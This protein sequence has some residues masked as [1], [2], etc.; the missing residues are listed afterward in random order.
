M[1]SIEIAEKYGF[2]PY[3]RKLRRGFRAHFSIRLDGV[4]LHIDSSPGEGWNLITH[5][6]S[7]HHGS[8]NM[9]NSSA[10]AS[11]ETA[12]ILEI[13]TRRKFSGMTFEVGS[14]LNLSGI[15]IKTYPTYHIKGAAAFLIKKARVLITGDVKNWRSLPKCDVLVT[16]A[17]YG[18]PSY[19][20]EDEIDKLLSAAER[21]SVFGAYPIGKAQRVAEILLNE[22][23]EFTAERRIRSICEALG[24][25][26]G[27]S[28]SLIVPPRK[29]SRY[30]GYILTA[31][32]FYRWPRIVLSDHID[33]SGIL[34]MVEHCNAE[35]VIFYHGCPTKRLKEDLSGMGVSSST[36]RDIDVYL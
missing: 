11:S 22:G 14:S 9:K 13:T 24:L 20:F 31:Q 12:K 19:T 26:V 30:R 35:H 6:H 3:R 32:R 34:R 36:L 8:K 33:Y 4:D 18:H 5:A 17:T 15:K 16:E 29:L 27:D 23:Y 28:G 7:D 1:N 25:K 21:G 10:V 2:L